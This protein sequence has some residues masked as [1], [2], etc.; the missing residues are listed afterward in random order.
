MNLTTAIKRT[1]FDYY[2]IQELPKKTIQELMELTEKQYFTLVPIA[3]KMDKQK[4]NT[5]L[6]ETIVKRKLLAN[7]DDN[8]V[9]KAAMDIWKSKHKV[10]SNVSI[11]DIE[12]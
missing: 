4:I 5:F 12:A 8:D 11:L 10:P 7:P 2:I 1:F 6:M 9:L 3:K